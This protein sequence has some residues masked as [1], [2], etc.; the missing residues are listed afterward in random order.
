MADAK[1]TCESCVFWLDQQITG[2]CRRYPQYQ[3]KSAREWCGEY[4][5]D[6]KL[7]PP[8]R[9]YTRRNHAETAEGQG[10][11]QAASAEVE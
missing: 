8:K 5:S 2:V 1:F 10:S 4:L 6:I 9:K 3:H 7:E 11:N